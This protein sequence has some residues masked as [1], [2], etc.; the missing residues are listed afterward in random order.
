MDL[1]TA[2]E[3][4]SQW[5]L[6]GYV[7]ESHPEL[8]KLLSD[9][10]QR[11]FLTYRGEPAPWATETAL[12][13]LNAW[14]R[15]TRW[16]CVCWHHPIMWREEFPAGDPEYFS[17]ST[18]ESEAAVTA[19]RFEIPAWNWPGGE[20]KSEFKDRFYAV[21]DRAFTEHVREAREWTSRSA[22][23]EPVYSDGLAMWQAGRALREIHSRLHE[24]GLNVGGP[25]PTDSDYNSAISKGLDKRAKLIQLDRRPQAV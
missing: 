3:T 20:I 25:D 6:W 18:G 16:T 9:W 13:T 7:Q 23:N 22:I 15:V 21:C 8:A 1:Q 2:C 10:A 4:S 12:T 5:T 17:E 11:F 14:A 19:I 24:R